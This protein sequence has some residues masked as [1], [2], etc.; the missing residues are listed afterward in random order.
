MASD[1]AIIGTL[2]PFGGT[3]TIE[4]WA[5]CSGQ[6][7]SISQF[8]ALYSLV[9]TLYGGDGRVSFGV[10]DLRGRSPVGM[11]QIPGSSHIYQQ[12]VKQGREELVLAVSQI[13][14]HTHGAVF[15]P[16]AAQAITGKF[17][18]A[19]DEA[20]INTPTTQTYLG[21]NASPNFYE[22]GF[23]GA[24]LVEI[25]GLTITGG[26]SGGG[27]VSIGSTGNSV[28]VNVINPVMPLNWL[29]ALEGV[30]PPRS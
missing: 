10:P 28:P 1:P 7:L 19:T 13:P 16:Y 9:G 8:Q 15:T 26:G 25:P 12:G 30:Y 2:V 4:S 6:L 5:S 23:G 18:V 11:G 17:E 3:F 27:T 20:T 29:I 14:A 22:P 21:T 24:N